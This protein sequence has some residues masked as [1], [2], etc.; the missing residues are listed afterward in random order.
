MNRFEGQS[1][2]ERNVMKQNFVPHLQIVHTEEERLENETKQYLSI[3]KQECTE[4]QFSLILQ[5]VDNCRKQR[6][7]LLEQMDML[8]AL[9]KES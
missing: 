7:I 2:P 1:D 6:M 3:L 9:T 5:I 4:D 8:E